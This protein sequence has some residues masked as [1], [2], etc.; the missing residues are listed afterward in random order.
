MGIEEAEAVTAD[1]TAD[2]PRRV[3]EG[4]PDLATGDPGQG[5]DQ[6]TEVA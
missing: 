6:G 1:P 2:L 3:K 5:E 4:F